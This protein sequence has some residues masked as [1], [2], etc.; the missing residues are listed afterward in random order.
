MFKKSAGSLDSVDELQ[1]L[2]DDAKG[3]TA[4]AVVTVEEAGLETVA[5]NVD[6]Q[7]FTVMVVDVAGVAVAVKCHK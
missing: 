2:V 5:A 7:G 6:L 1:Q 4:A 3:C